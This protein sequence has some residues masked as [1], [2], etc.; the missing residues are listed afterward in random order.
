MSFIVD[1]FGVLK[2]KI[3]VVVLA[4]DA[5]FWYKQLGILQLLL[6]Q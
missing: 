6:F 1:R 5:Y 4:F 3:I 2:D